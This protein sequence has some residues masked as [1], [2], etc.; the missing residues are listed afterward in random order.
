MQEKISRVPRTGK[1]RNARK[2]R[3]VATYLRALGLYG[4]DHFDAVVLAALASEAPLLLIGAH[5][6]AKSALLIAPRRCSASSTG[7]TTPAWSP[8]TTC[9]AFRFPT[10]RVMGCSTCAPPILEL[11]R[12]G[13]FGQ[14]L[15]T[16][17]LSG[18]VAPI[19]TAVSLTDSTIMPLA[20]STS[21]KGSSNPPC[22]ARLLST[23][24][25]SRQGAQAGTQAIDVGLREEPF[26]L[27]VRALPDRHGRSQQCTAGLCQG[28]KATAP[29]GRIDRDLDEPV[30]LER[31]QV[32]GQRGAIHCQ[33]LSHRADRRRLGT[34]KRHQQRELAA[35]NADGAQRVIE[36][37]R[38]GTRCPLRMQTQAVVPDMNRGLQRNEIGR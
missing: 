37:A 35:G 14:R 21:G 17:C 15:A 18:Y 36:A 30:P 16:G 24:R 13:A 38:Q 29:V 23:S 28:Q 34:I 27:F 19:V 26:S 1:R 25:A 3:G 7:T 22:A 4:L 20:L 33:E 11:A 12:W 2:S 6:S 32:G 10:P 5:C 8:L 9:S 31:L